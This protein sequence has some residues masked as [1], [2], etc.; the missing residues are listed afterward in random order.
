MSWI[1]TPE[2][3]DEGINMYLN[4]FHAKNSSTESS[5]SESGSKIIVSVPKDNAFRQIENIQLIR[6]RCCGNSTCIYCPECCKVLVSKSNLPDSLQNNDVCLPFDLDIIL[7]DRRRAATGLHALMLLKDT[8]S[9]QDKNESIDP[10]SN[11]QPQNSADIEVEGITS[12]CKLDTNQHRC[13]ASATKKCGIVTLID[14]DKG[15][16]IPRYET[17][18]T[19]EQ[20]LNTRDMVKNK[21]DDELCCV[22]F[23]SKD[24]VPLSSLA[25]RISRLIVLDCKWTKS[26]VK[27][28]QNLSGLT[29]VS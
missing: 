21:E 22:L 12:T 24:S 3:R 19:R 7:D 23:P 20:S 15:D 6:S 9:S 17:S 11:S 4:S 10:T 13:T 29:K 8:N 27:R 14:L 5:D 18:R 28:C 2:E 25:H 26:S 1:Q 16:S